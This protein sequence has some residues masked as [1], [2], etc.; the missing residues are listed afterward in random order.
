MQQK[1]NALADQG[2]DAFKNTKNNAE[3]VNGVPTIIADGFTYTDETQ[4]YEI[5]ST[6]LKSKGFSISDEEA[7]KL[8][9]GYVFDIK[10]QG[11]APDFLYEQNGLEKGYY[12][13]WL[14]TEKAKLE[15][16]INATISKYDSYEV[17]D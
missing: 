15:K 8:Y 6:I 9:R 10:Y 1:L 14:N 17:N 7:K 11:Q 2:Y 4:D 13:N 3:L 5:F 16:S 12:A